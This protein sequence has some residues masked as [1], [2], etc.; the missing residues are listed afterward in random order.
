MPTN[1]LP[2]AADTL[3]GVTVVVTRPR[4]Q[5]A[6][7][8]HL[9][10][11]R[12]GR[13]VLFPVLE[14]IDVEDSGPARALI[15][16]L[17]EFDLAIFVSANAVHKAAPMIA[18]R[19]GFPARLR[20]AAI[21]R[22][23]AEVLQAHGLR[24]DIQ[25]QEGFTSE[26]LLALPEMQNVQGKNIVIFRGTGGRALLGETLTQRGAHVSY[27]EVY[28]RVRPV[29][30]GAELV[31]VLE[32]NKKV[33]MVVTSNEG[34]QNLFEMAGVQGQ[35]LLRHT[36]LV[37]MSARNAECA[38]SLGFGKAVVA[39]QADDEGLIDGVITAAQHN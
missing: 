11:A 35:P 20:V 7:L 22:R 38:R 23:T 13:A 24:A 16:R 2:I 37:V 8:C 10:E 17:D 33:V 14:I 21:G 15:Q 26:A 9:I 32:D 29:C 6:R 18:A 34:L 4:H 12:G 19:A 27:A 3:A 30:E 1:A 39:E 28:R 31:R 5:A 25:P 36:R